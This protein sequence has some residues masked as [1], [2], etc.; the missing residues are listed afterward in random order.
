MGEP[1]TVRQQGT[2]VRAPRK[3]TAWT[4]R[5]PPETLLGMFFIVGADSGMSQPTVS[6]LTANNFL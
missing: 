5:D 4:P 2:S 6:S 3:S 1:C